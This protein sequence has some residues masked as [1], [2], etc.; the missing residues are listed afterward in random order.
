MT[1]F[2]Y[3]ESPDYK[4]GLERLGYEILAWEEFGSY[5][6]DYAAIVKSGSNI[7]FVV[8]GY[9][10]CS[11]CDELQ[12]CDWPW[13]NNGSEETKKRFEKADQEIRS[14]FEGI[15]RSIVWGSPSDLTRFILS[16]ERS[17]LDWYRHDSSFKESRKNLVEALKA[18]A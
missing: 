11:G 3:D 7:G 13:W 12:A 17:G 6:G 18:V 2:D 4:L 14:L 9:G 1:L 10:S 8:I 15:E 5:Q 16:N